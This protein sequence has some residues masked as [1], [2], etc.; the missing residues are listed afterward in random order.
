MSKKGSPARDERRFVGGCVEAY[1]NTSMNEK[2]I[3][4]MIGY[5]PESIDD[6]RVSENN[7]D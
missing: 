1:F 4:S 6:I 3:I 2:W 7:A 5:V